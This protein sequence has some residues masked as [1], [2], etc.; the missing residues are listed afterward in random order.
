MIS[1]KGLYGLTAG[2]ITTGALQPFENIKMA[3]MISPKDLK[4]TNN[5][6]TNV[7]RA[8][9]YINRVDGWKGFYKGLVAATQKAALGCYIYFSILRHLEG[10]DEDQTRSRNFMASPAARIASTILTNPLSIIETRFE[11]ADFH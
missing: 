9:E 6:L 10:D 3:L 5:F 8:S 11:L 2:I 4:M 7:V 1:D